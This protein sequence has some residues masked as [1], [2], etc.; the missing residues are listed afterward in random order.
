MI[1][2]FGSV[3]SIYGQKSLIA[4]LDL[5]VHALSSESK[6]LFDRFFY[7]ALELG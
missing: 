5:N 2:I 3:R 4:R 1:R 6:N 7:F